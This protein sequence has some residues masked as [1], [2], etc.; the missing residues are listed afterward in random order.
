MTSV[1]ARREKKRREVG[2]SSCASGPRCPAAQPTCN[3][4]HYFSQ[5]LSSPIGLL[6]A[7]A[8]IQAPS[9]RWREVPYALDSW[10]A[11][12]SEV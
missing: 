8:L 11:C 12:H 9:F 4:S 6:P 10:H 7:P 5:R 3:K 2:P 1:P